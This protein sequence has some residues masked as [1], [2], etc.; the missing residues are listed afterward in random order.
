MNIIG[1]KSFGFDAETAKAIGIINKVATVN[2]FITLFLKKIV[3]DINKVVH[4]QKAIIDTM[5]NN[6]AFTM[7]SGIKSMIPKTNPI[8]IIK[9]VF[10]IFSP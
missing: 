3:L 1:K 6:G 8:K 4:N 10:F 5:L 9:N 2:P 7:N